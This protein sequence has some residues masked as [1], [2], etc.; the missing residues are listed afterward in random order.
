MKPIKNNTNTKKRSEFRYH[1][2]RIKTRNGKVRIHD[3]PTYIFLESGD[4]FIY[5]PITHSKKVKGQIVIKL[6]KNPNP[7]DLRDSYYIEDFSYD[8]AENFG[9]KRDGWSIVENDD[10]EIRELYNKKSPK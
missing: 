4:I 8:K 1:A 2:V 10:K 7:E 9:R 5:V 3:H 6:R